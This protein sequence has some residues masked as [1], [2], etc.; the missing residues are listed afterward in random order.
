MSEQLRIL[1]LHRHGYFSNNAVNLQS[2]AVYGNDHLF[3]YHD[4]SAPVIP[5]VSDF[6]WDAIILSFC[7]L[8]RRH[9]PAFQSIKERYDF[10]RKSNAVKVAFPQDDYI[11]YRLLDDWLADWEVDLVYTP[12]EKNIEVL[13]PR[14]SQQAKIIS[15]YTGYI[16]DRRDPLFRHYALP[17]AERP[18]QFGNRI[19]KLPATY[20]RHGVLKGRM[21]ETF[22]MMLQAR[23]WTCDI[24]T[25]HKDRYYDDEWMKFLGRIQFTLAAKGG[26]SVADPDGEIHRKVAEFKIA[27]PDASFEE[28]EEACFPGEDGKY[29]FDAI[30]PRILQASQMGACQILP[31]DDY[32]GGLIAGT[33][34][35]KIEPDLSNFE[36]VFEQMQDTQACAAIANRARKKLMSN[37]EL[38]YSG[39][40]EQLYG[41]I[42]RLRKNRPLADAVSGVRGAQN[43]KLINALEL[44]ADREYQKLERLDPDLV[45]IVMRAVSS[46]DN[47]KCNR[48]ISVC[49]SA[50][51][52]SPHQTML[53]LEAQGFNIAGFSIAERS[54]ILMYFRFTDE[55]KRAALLDMVMQQLAGTLPAM[56]STNYRNNILIS[57]DKQ[58]NLVFR[59]EAQ[60]FSMSKSGLALSNAQLKDLKGRQLRLLEDRNEIQE[61]IGNVRRKRVLCLFDTSFDGHVR[62][63]IEALQKSDRNDY[64]FVNPMEDRAADNLDIQAFDGVYIDYSI[65]VHIDSYLSPRMRARLATFGGPIIRASQDEYRWVSQA[66]SAMEEIGVSVLISSLSP[67]NITKVYGRNFLDKVI[68]LQSPPGF[69]NP[70]I[71]PERI[72]PLGERESLLSARTWDIKDFKPYYGRFMRKK[73]ELAEALGEAAGSMGVPVNIARSTGGRVYGQA[74]GETL[75]ESRGHLA[76]EGGSTMFDLDS[77]FERIH[78][79]YLARNPY[80]TFEEIYEE[81]F[82]QYENNVIH[83]VMTPRCIEAAAVGTVIVGMK[84]DYSGFLKPDEDYIVIADDG[85]NARDVLEQLQD[86]PHI[87]KIAERAMNKLARNSHLTYQSHVHRLDTL[88]DGLFS[89]DY[90]PR[91]EP[92]MAGVAQKPKPYEA[93]S[94]EPRENG[95]ASR[96][97][98]GVP[99]PSGN[100]S[101]RKTAT[102]SKRSAKAAPRRRAAGA[103]KA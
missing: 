20:G 31:L 33:D 21:N 32:P 90:E 45:P 38:T 34:Y 47:E 80:A 18:I 16:D 82:A 98:P 72:V 100:A 50:S 19:N 11:R 73:H 2:F 37:R 3:Y 67:E 24:S 41:E 9:D 52:K 17:F 65:L 46:L 15:C 99:A 89:G 23:G 26:V 62:Y 102:G 35:I 22:G 12:M 5:E 59:E 13:Y 79:A 69:L 87:E 55:S 1:V 36:H 78:D 68:A 84:G 43:R 44:S 94:G 7:A 4:L 28:I 27:N 103:K 60:P 48:V 93:S 77:R 81:V 54:L 75:M 42:A 96:S 61:K 83:K 29:M 86:V 30:G 10:V 91:R 57:G 39:F 63:M 25:A 76:L 66:V 40:M 101:T 64:V 70:A 49:R 71:V 8:G 88:I 97:D 95:K 85:S 58:S 92:I 6:P 53:S 74:W 51:S 14:T 56:V